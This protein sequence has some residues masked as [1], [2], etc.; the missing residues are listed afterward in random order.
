MK[1]KYKLIGTIIFVFTLLISV[2][3]ALIL[4][5]E[6]KLTEKIN[7]NLL[8]INS[9][10]VSEIE[11]NVNLR[12]EY[13]EVF[14]V[15]PLVRQTVIDS[16]AQFDQIKNLP[17]LIAQ[18]DK[19]WISVPKE[20]ITPFMQDIL[21]NEFSGRLTA[22]KEFYE[23]EYNYSIYPEVFVTNKYG[24]VIGTTGKTTDYYQADEAWWQIAKDKGLYI[25]DV[26]YDDSSNTYSLI[27][28]VRIDDEKGNFI[29]V[30]KFLISTD[31]II[32][33]FQKMIVGEDTPLYASISFELIN[34]KK[35]IIY[36]TG[37]PGHLI[38]LSAH[39]LE[40]FAQ[41]EQNEGK[42][43]LVKSEISGWD[44]ELIVHEH[45]KNEGTLQ[46]LN[47]TLILEFDHDKIFIPV[48]ELKNKSVFISLIIFILALSVILWLSRSIYN[49]LH[50]L[51]QTTEKIE[52]GD[53]NVH[54][55]IRSKD[56]LGKL[57]RSFNHMVQQLK[58][59]K[60]QLRRNEAEKR[61]GVER[62]NKELDKKVTQ[63]TLDLE[64]KNKE[65]EEAKKATLNLVEDIEEAQNKLKQSY[66]EL[67]GLDKLKTEFLSMASHELRTPLTPIKSQIQRLLSLNLD[68]EQ[69]RGSLE[70]IL[71]NAVRLDRLTQD[72]LEVARIESKKMILAKRKTDINHLLRQAIETLRPLAEDK[73]VRIVL[74]L[75]PLPPI[76]VDEHRITSV[77]INLLDNAIKY[78]GNEVRISSE[79]KSR[80]ILISFAD[81]GIGISEEMKPKLFDLFVRGK[82]EL[83]Q[84]IG[85]TGLGLAICKGIIEAHHGKIWVESKLGRGS[86]FYFSLP[87][88]P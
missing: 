34:G 65:A 88:N 54:L 28:A 69:R 32:K 37:E 30:V 18:R 16:N 12:V 47:W 44:Q 27:K 41:L 80:S 56:E 13:W 48:K 7:D 20:E 61:L 53:L 29:G 24:A 14:A 82:E 17:D 49:P 57:G 51:H 40:E 74:N 52:K 26:E 4:I 62:L 64:K 83:V 33:N 1:I 81:K 67:K 59:Q 45:F 35:E 15:L 31:E 73:A 85:G 21:D 38:P 72:I 79:V 77:L 19:E 5:S 36:K 2:N 25:G 68:K 70:M 78:G 8:M 66:E 84:Q 86:T 10:V 87:I 46:S 63:R 50:Q 3:L 9:L 71:R 76:N 60:E 43:F 6:Q 42:V 39:E 23:K 55:E 58:S 11:K 75:R 22:R